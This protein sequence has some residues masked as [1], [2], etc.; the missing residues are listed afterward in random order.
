MRDNSAL[1][2]LLRC[3]AYGENAGLGAALRDSSGLQRNRVD[4]LAERGGFEPPRPFRGL[5]ALQACAINQAQPP[6]RGKEVCHPNCASRQWNRTAQDWRTLAGLQ[7]Y[8]AVAQNLPKSTNQYGIRG[9]KPSLLCQLRADP[10]SRPPANRRERTRR[11]QNPG[12]A[13]SMHAARASFCKRS[14]S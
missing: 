13:V 2:S 9:K 12:R 3:A 6:L 7:A 4:C 10:A 1:A 11:K 14:S 8:A 5:H